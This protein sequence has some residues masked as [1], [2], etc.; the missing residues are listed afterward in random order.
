[1]SRGGNVSGG[2]YSFNKKMMKG[3][4]SYR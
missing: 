2:F 1:M 3:V 4:D